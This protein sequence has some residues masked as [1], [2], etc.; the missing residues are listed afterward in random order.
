[1]SFCALTA[2]P[3]TWTRGLAWIMC[4][5]AELLEYLDTVDDAELAAVGGRERMR[6]MMLAAAV[7]S[8]DFYID[9]TPTD[10]VPY[11]DTGAPGLHQMGNF[12][13]RP[14]EPMNR[15]EPVDASAATIAAQGLL[16]L[17]RV[18]S[19][20][21]DR[22]EKAALTVARTLLDEPY[23]ATD[24]RHQ[25]LLLHS[26]YHRPNGWDAIPAGQQVPC[27]ESSMWGDYHLIELALLV[28]RIAKGEYLTFFDAEGATP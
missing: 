19:A 21:R 27:G 20:G 14:A 26:V 23:L 16:R 15:F 3:T 11:W 28:Q 17:A 10:G 22:Y 9:E 18:A 1:M 8:C 2:I 6:T 24:P 7:A 25:G 5:Y 12:L 4:G 13:D